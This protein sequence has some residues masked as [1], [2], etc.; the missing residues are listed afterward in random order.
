M[1]GQPVR[2]GVVGGG[3]MGKELLALTRRWDALVDHPSRPEVVA[4]ADP[5]PG[6]QQWWRQ[7]G[8]ATVTDD[9]RLL[10]DDPGIDV[11]YLAV[12][13]DVHERLYLDAVSAR[14]DF[15]GEKPFGIDLGAATRIVAAI[16]DSDC[17]V[18]VSSEL[19]FFPGAQRA[20]GLVRDGVLGEV[21]EVRSGLLHSSDLDRD[22]P[23]NWKRRKATCG[24]IGVMGDLGMHA[25][26]L[27][28]R[29]GWMPRTVYA[30]LDDVVRTRPGADGAP[31]PCDTWDNAVLALTVDVPDRRFPMLWETKRIAPGQSNTWFFEAYGMDGGVRFSTRSPQTLQRFGM[32]DGEQAWSE[33]QPGHRSVWPTVT[34]A[35]F[36]FGFPDALLQMWA[37]FLGER[38]GRLEGGFG[39]ATPHE[40]LASHRVFAAALRSHDTGT[41]VELPA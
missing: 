8:V 18:R 27:P 26:H 7:A 3:L 15:L 21:L 24:E 36:E 5:S 34:G 13:H 6:V 41:A 30:L 35:I 31:V 29:L 17:F 19:P 2:I 37:V 25:A 4:L 11:L 1:T 22:K 33:V 14:K 20:A 39:T 16:D 40:A 12:P 38:A 23:G 10:L 32:V 9:Y 28:L